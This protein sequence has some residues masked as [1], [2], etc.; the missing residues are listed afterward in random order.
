MSLNGKAKWHQ[1]RVPF[2]GRGF[3]SLVCLT[4]VGSAIQHRGH[5]VAFLEERIFEQMWCRCAN[6]F[7]AL[8]APPCGLV[9]LPM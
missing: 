2:S 1:C 9:L 5:S 4:A 3:P 6:I 7:F 8:P